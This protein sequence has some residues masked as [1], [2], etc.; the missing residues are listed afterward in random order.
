LTQG[1]AV[2]AGTVPLKTMSAPKDK[3]GVGTT[4]I[5]VAEP[6][7]SAET[8]IKTNTTNHKR[9]HRVIVVS[10]LKKTVMAGIVR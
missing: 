10:P 1:F 7:V 9:M 5:A 4:T 8:V 6:A 3:S 2:E